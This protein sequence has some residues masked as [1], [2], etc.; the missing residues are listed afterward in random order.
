[1]YDFLCYSPIDSYIPKIKQGPA[2]FIRI[3]NLSS[4][5]KRA[6]IYANERIIA[7]NISFKKFTSYFVIP[8]GQYKLN[9]YASGKSSLPIT[10]G[11][12]NFIPDTIYTCV[13]CGTHQAELIIIIDP[14][15]N[16]DPE[17]ANIRLV[18]LSQS[19]PEFN[20][21]KSDNTILFHSGNYK[22]IS[23]Y[24]SLPP[25]KYILKAF[26][27]DT[28]K[29]LFVLTEAEIKSGWN[30]TLYVT[31]ASK[32]QNIQPILLI[33]GSTYIKTKS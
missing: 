6:D 29:N 13:I 30:Y 32:N 28:Y 24:Y 3:I 15:I 10:E 12:F 4:A 23:E 7:K 17:K 18:H 11:V 21:V 27:P 16:T 25:G 33:D 1:M 31:E 22:N 20:I 19:A 26:I 14:I 2:S 9:I 5:L 8:S